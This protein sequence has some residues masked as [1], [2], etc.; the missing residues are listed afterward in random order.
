[1]LKTLTIGSAGEDPIRPLV[2]KMAENGHSEP[3]VAQPL[4]VSIGC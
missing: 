3:S 4:P 1:M 2:D